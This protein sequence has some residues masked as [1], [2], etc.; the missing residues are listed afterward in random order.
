MKQILIFLK[1]KQEYFYMGLAWFLLWIL[2]WGRFTSFEGNLYLIFFVDMLKLGV[3]LGMFILPGALLYILLRQENDPLFEPWG[4]LP[5]GFALSV[6]IIAVIGIL[7]R[8]LGF[9]FVLVKNIFMLIGLGELILSA[10]FKPNFAIRKE[11]FLESFRSILNNPPLLLALVLAAL[12]TFHDYLFFIDD[13]TYLAY[14]TNWQHASHLGFKNIIHDADVMEHARFWLAMYPMGQA[15]LSDLSGVPGIL[16]MSSYLELYL[17][18]M[19]ALTSYWF[20]R[21]LGLSRR[22]AGFSVLIQ[23]ALYSW[24][25]GDQWP[26]GTWF[27]QSLA[28]DKVSA[29]FFLSPVFFVFVLRFI[30]NPTINNIILVFLSGTGIMLTHPVILFLLCAIALGIGFFSWV[31]KQSTWRAVVQLLLIFACLTLPYAVI[32]LSD[33]SG[34]VSGPYNGKEASSTFQIER[35]TNVMSDV[36]YGLNPGVLK[37][38]DIQPENRVYFAYQFVRVI[39]IVLVLLAGILA[40]AKLKNGPLH[41]YV[42]SSALLVFLAALPY[43]GW[44][45]GYFVS[46]RMI[47]RAS[48]FSPLGLAAALVSISLLDW[49]K[50]K[51]GIEPGRLAKL[52][53]TLALSG[54]VFSFILISPFL[55]SNNLPRLPAYFETLAYN[56]QLAQ[57]G[58]YIDRNTAG[59]VT[60][61]ALD[62]WDTQLLPGVASHAVLISFREELDYNGFNNFMSLDEIHDR[63]YASNT[64]RSLEPTIPPEEKCNLIKKYNVKF[65]VA[66]SDKAEDYGNLVSACGMTTEVAFETEEL[67][68]LGF[69]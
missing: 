5:I 57:I 47:S 27:Y 49:L 37:F 42:S 29:V 38:L 4:I 25:V 64:I 8:L 7:G 69:K 28:E 63:I 40:L 46:A 6:T 11:Y 44:I 65:V 39:P 66:R 17:V 50:S 23:V 41:W 43:T 18:P 54:F 13:T 14:L 60:V 20:A 55:L 67:V 2:P 16:L 52:H 3:A 24:M 12:L 22:A 30:R 15:L 59:Q 53:K 58:A 36:Y 56:K 21:T 62:Y 26:V 34:E 19:A 45:I 48:W 33:S 10:F 35:Y 9:S 68:L 51:P 1:S 32:R 31:S 61:I